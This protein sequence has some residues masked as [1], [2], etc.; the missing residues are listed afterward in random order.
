M[1]NKNETG[2]RDNVDSREWKVHGNQ[3][4][5][6]I[7]EVEVEVPINHPR[8]VDSCSG[9]GFFPDPD[10]C[11]KFVKCSYI[12]RDD[13]ILLVREVFD[14]PPG[15]DLWCQSIQICTFAFNCPQAC[16]S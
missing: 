15:S 13:N 6:V 5:S 8:T 7:P 16:S 4:V 9:P 3:S 1:E 2:T 14:C 12:E 10:D 11:M